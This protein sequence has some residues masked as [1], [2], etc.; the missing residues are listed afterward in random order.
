MSAGEIHSD[1]APRALATRLYKRHRLIYAGA[2]AALI[3]TNIYI[4]SGWWTF[5]P[6]CAWTIV[7]AFHFFYY[8]SITIDEAWVEERTDDMRLRSYDLSH[9]HDIENRVEHRDASVR[10]SD[11]RDR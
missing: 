6:M 9:I 5:W 11:E 1:P 8:K 7:F 3:I 2:M 4:G 10:P